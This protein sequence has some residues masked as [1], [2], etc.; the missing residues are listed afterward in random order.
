MEAITVK[1]FIKHVSELNSNNQ[2]GFSE[3]F[4]VNG[5][6]LYVQTKQDN[7]TMLKFLYLQ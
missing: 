6:V 2:H 1:Q 3:D 7:V 4:E 5:T